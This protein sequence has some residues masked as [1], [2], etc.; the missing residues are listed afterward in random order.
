[1]SMGAS[2]MALV[3]PADGIWPR[4]SGGLGRTADAPIVQTSM[5]FQGLGSTF[6]Q[7]GASLT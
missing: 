7:G 6:G 5:L 2:P 1:M 4:G 3:R